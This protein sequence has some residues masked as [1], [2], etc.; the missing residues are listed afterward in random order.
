MCLQII[1]NISIAVYIV[2]SKQ[3]R[4]ENVAMEKGES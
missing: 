2:F 3:V 4:I 1:K